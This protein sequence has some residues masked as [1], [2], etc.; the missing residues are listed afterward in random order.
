M[1]YISTAEVDVTYHNTWGRTIFQNPFR[2][3]PHPDLSLKRRDGFLIPCLHPCTHQQSVVRLSHCQGC[4]L[5]L[6]Y[7]KKEKLQNI[8]LVTNVQWWLFPNCSVSSVPRN[9]LIKLPSNQHGLEIGNYCRIIHIFT[10][11]YPKIHIYIN[12]LGKCKVCK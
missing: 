9:N 4:P 11:K 5:F 1:S 2:F 8:N 6:R 7:I 10:Y 3:Y 12:I